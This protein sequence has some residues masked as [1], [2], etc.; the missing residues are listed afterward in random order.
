MRFTALAML[1]AFAMPALAQSDAVVI[2]ATRFPED[3]RRLP[4]SVTVLSTED[5]QKSA[6]RTLPELLSEQV[7]LTMK[8]F[9]GNNA[10]ST[11]VDLR[12]FGAT[13]TQNTLMLVDGRRVTDTDLSG[14]Q[15]AAIP[16]AAVERIEILRG[17]GAV[18]YGDGA[19]T[20]VVNIVM[21]SPLKQ[22]HRAEALGRVASYGTL[23]GQLYGSATTQ[24][25]GINAVL[26]G[27]ESAGYRDNN[28]N[29]QQNAGVNLRWG[30]AESY[31]D[32]R[33]GL[34][35]QDLRLPGA[36]RVQPSIG[37]DEYATDPRGAQTPLDWSTRDGE[38]AGVT[39]GT[40]LG[41]VELTVGADW[42][43]KSQQSYFDQSGFPISRDD[44]L[45]V[46]ALTPRVR[47]PFALAGMRHSVTAG[48][49]WYAW[50][51]DSRR[52]D[53]PQ[54]IEQPINRVRVDQDVQGYYLQDAIELTGT[55]L[56]TLG[57]REER[58]KY[59]ATDTLDPTAPGAGFATQAPAV[60]ETQ[61]QHAWEVGL[62][63]ALSAGTAV[64][65]RAQRSFRF[66][67]ADEIYEDDASF[68]KQFQILRPQTAHTY[69]LGAER[70]L[71]AV[72]ARATLFR[73]DVE[74]EIHLDPFTTGVGNRNL[75]PS[76]RQGVELESGWQATPPLK[77]TAGYAYTDAKFLEGTL[78][79]GPFVIGSGL[80]IAG[81]R[82]PLVPVHKL[83]LGVAWDIDARTRL[84]GALTA[85]SDQYMDNDE[86]NT[87][88]A[89]IPAYALVD[90]K[91]ARDFGW[92][93]L[94]AAVN[95][96]FDERYYTYAVRSQFVADRY[97]VYP[98]PGRTY[99]LAL[100]LRLD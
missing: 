46:E 50:R 54:N 11:A 29:E 35:R 14:V 37:L 41:K 78:P 10:A 66:V 84:S 95:N 20:G 13:A 6:A 77:L 27:Y 3:A 82:V 74:D 22:G 60:Q 91:L 38:R 67:N 5:I 56:L 80:S 12:G 61:K 23:E 96:L 64:F 59:D 24:A 49:D 16:L 85:L 40:R 73:M 86:P 36:R 75:P 47:V 32:L 42:R 17:T 25:F 8:D 21:R 28:R 90:A 43:G 81:K 34:D 1:A 18:L 51:Y 44:Q 33:L 58:V 69:E 68:S 87:L 72:F 100:E 31:L 39:F 55:S 76:R 93:R 19:T 71:G 26:Q 30:L 89:K 45:E 62:R 2:N 63:Q 99:S 48:A 88:G 79:G 15:W 7:G 83:N 97:A 9:Y 52:S 53:L 4:A 98:L 92:A 94:S 57:W 65:V 70:R